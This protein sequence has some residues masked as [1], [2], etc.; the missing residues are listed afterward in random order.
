MIMSN[1]AVVV[2]DV[3]NAVLSVPG[4]LRPAETMAALDACVARIAG[5][6]VGARR[7]DIPIL[8]VQHDGTVGHRLKP[9]SV[10]WQIRPELTPRC[11]E[12]VVHKRASDSFFHTTLDAE[13]QS[14]KIGRLIVAGCMTQYCVDTTVRRAA[15][16]GYDVTLV[17]DGHMTADFSVLTFEQI[18]AHHN[19]L[20]DGFDADEH[21]VS[22]VPSEQA[23]L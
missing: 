1:T 5:L 15:T 10:G 22:V 14:R 4:M 12:P 18:I 7:S 8:F 9:G 21:L 3:Q 11:S 16:L 6:L 23:M 13:L 20:L 2:I 19:E 17:A